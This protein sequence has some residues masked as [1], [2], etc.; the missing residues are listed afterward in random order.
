MLQ[1]R[2]GVATTIYFTLI[3]FGATDFLTGAAAASGDIKIIKDGGAAANTTTATFTE[4]GHGWYSVPLTATEMQ[5]R[6][7]CLSIIDQTNPKEWEDQGVLI[8]TVAHASAEIP[9][10]ADESVA[11]VKTKTDNLPSDPA[12]ASVIA[13]ATDAIAGYIDTEVAAIKAKTDLIPASP[14]AVSDIPTAIENADA[15]LKRDFDQVEATAPIHSLLS[16]GLKL[17][18]RFVASTGKTYRT[19]GTT[20]HMTQTPTSDADAEP[21]T[22]LSAAA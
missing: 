10:L 1:R 20:E 16:A 2:Y 14:A 12:D 18:S 6:Q 3:D 8:H 19:D 4:E 17:V 15:L 7:I 9:Y 21:I 5:A 11:A 13:A 22:E